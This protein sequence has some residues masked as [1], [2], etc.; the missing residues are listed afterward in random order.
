[1]KTMK[2]LFF[3]ALM[4][5]AILPAFAQRG[6]HTRIGSTEPVRRHPLH[7]G[8]LRAAG[9]HGY[10]DVRP[11]EDDADDGRSASGE[12]DAVHACH[13]H[14]HV[15]NVCVGAGHLLGVEQSAHHRATDVHHA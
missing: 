8:D 13:L 7:R 12:D 4:Q 1:M 9:A 10:H 15:L 11:A 6:R 14:L 5:I 3:L 2:T